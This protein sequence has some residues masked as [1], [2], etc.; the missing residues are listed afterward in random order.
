MSDSTTNPS[1]G[2]SAILARLE[3]IAQRALV[4]AATVHGAPDDDPFRGLHLGPDDVARI[5]ER[6]P[7]V[8]LYGAVDP[9]P[10]DDGAIGDRLKWLA[11]AYRLTEFD[12]TTAYTRCASAT[13]CWY[14]S[15]EGSL[16][17]T[18]RFHA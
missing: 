11:G 5:L 8:P 2:V 16:V 17:S 13:K 9:P 3:A 4:V 15:R 12:E 6:T 14:S 10:V 1:S 18:M 7:G